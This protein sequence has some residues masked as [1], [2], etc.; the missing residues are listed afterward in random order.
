MTTE[1]DQSEYVDC[2]I[3]RGG[4]TEVFVRGEGTARIVRCRNDGLLYRNPRPKPRD[5]KDFQTEFVPH[6]G[7]EWFVRR[8][9][10][11]S[12]AAEA[13]K[14]V[15]NSGTLLDIGCATGNF[16]ENFKDAKWR[17]YGLDPS[18]MGVEAAR[19]KYQAE[20]LCG[21]L[22]EVHY[23][24]RFFDVVT[25]M[26]ALYY[27]PD[28]KADLVE[29][30]RI[31]KDDG[32]LAVEIPGFAAM[33]LR[34]KGFLCWLLERKWE[35]LFTISGILYYFSPS[36]MRLLFEGAGFRLLRMVPGASVSVRKLGQAYNDF[37]FGLAW[38]LFKASA[39]QFSIAGRELYLG[40][41]A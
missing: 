4:A 15:K 16:F 31:L 7:L 37:Y 30:R 34:D 22:R 33:R 13:I 41:K 20:V 40:V 26:D 35:R 10:A 6:T 17:L 28:P 23:P 32:L 19:D 38:L 8:Q 25:V 21:T 12:K 39:G 5:L 9:R 14:R 29:I 3:C 36:T 2:I 11:L 18:P 24:D 27:S 1:D